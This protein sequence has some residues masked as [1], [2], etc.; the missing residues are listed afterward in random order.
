MGQHLG[1]RKESNAVRRH[2]KARGIE[3]EQCGFRLVAHGPIL[4]EGANDEVHRV[5]VEIVAS[6]ER[7]LA[8]AMRTAG[9]NVLNTVRCRRLL[10]QELFA[11]V[12]KGF[13]EKFPKLKKEKVASA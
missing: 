2:L 1:F 8:E 4:G 9:Y 10:D 13:W 3:A 12:L 7:A 11:G 5:R 6:M